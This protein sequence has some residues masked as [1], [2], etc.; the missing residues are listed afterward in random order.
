[1]TQLRKRVLEELDRRNYSQA[2]ARAY[3]AA[4]RRF[5]QYF[6]RSPDLLGRE[7]V[8]QYQVHLTAER[9]VHPAC[10]TM[11]PMPLKVR[12]VVRLLQ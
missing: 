6:H 11:G 10:S 5:A 3:V 2:T 8:R 7:H 12:E 9:K 1:V 4:I